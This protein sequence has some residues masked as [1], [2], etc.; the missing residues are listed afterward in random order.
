MR[1]FLAVTV[2]ASHA[3][4][5]LGQYNNEP[6]FRLSRGQID[7][8]IAAVD[9]FFAISGYLITSSWLNCSG[10]LDFLRRRAFRIYPGFIVT[11]LLCALVVGPL[12][13]DNVFAYFGQRDFIQFIHRPLMFREIYA[14][15]HIFSDNPIKGVP[16]AS[17]WT[18]RFELMCYLLVAV[19][20]LIG[21]L[22]RPL[23]VLAAFLACWGVH[24]FWNGALQLP[25]IDHLDPLPRLATYFLAGSVFFL[26]RDRIPFSPWIA[27]VSALALAAACFGGMNAVFPILGT[28]L[29]FWLAFHPRIP[30]HNAARFGDF[31]YGTYLFAYPVGQLLV[32]W[33]P[34]AWSPLT[35]FIASAAGTLPLAVASWYCVERPFLKKKKK[36]V[37]AV[38]A[39]PVPVPV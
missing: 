15:Q 18:I 20:G 33:F 4:A 7:G 28:Y 35:L 24:L 5:L 1:L 9:G 37:P 31:S 27:A 38:A 2:I 16:N 34:N 23:V 11:L 39:A 8:G 17:L 14:I 19:L 6:L 25:F 12:A 3:F 21:L 32:H 26:F 36:P 29:L 30:L 13:A 10:L 22:R